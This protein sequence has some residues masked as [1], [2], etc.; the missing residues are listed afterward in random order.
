MSNLHVLGKDRVHCSTIKP[1][2]VDGWTDETIKAGGENESQIGRSHLHC[3]ENFG[4]GKKK[5]GSRCWEEKRR[6]T[7]TSMSRRKLR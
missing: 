1:L 7:S 4:A 6:T 2:Q 5:F 3:G